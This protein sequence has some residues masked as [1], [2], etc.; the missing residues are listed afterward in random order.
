M[1][2]FSK[3]LISASLFIIFSA[4]L[5]AEGMVISETGSSGSFPL[6][7]GN[8][9]AALIVDT[10]DAEVVKIAAQAFSGDIKLLTGATPTIQSTINN[11]PPVIIGTLSKSAL[12]DQLA[13]SGKINKSRLEG[14]WE[15]FCIV[16][17][18]NPV[19]NASKALVVA[20]SDPRG[21][22]FGVFELSRMMGV[23]PWIWWADVIPETRSAIYVSGD[24]VFGPPSVKYRGIFI[25][26]EDWGMQP[27]AAN[28]M[29]TE[30]NGGK[31]DI[32]PKTYEHIFELMLRTKSNYLWPA[33]HAC[34]KAFWYYKENVEVARRYSIVMGSS[35]CEPML[36]NNEDE[37][38]SNFS[39]EYPGVTRGD[40]NWKTNS[41]VIKNYWIDRV[42][43]SV[44]N[45]AVY[46]LGM[47]GVHDTQML[48][49]NNDDERAAALKQI[50]AAQRDILETYLQKSKE[51]I[52][53][54]FC[55][56][57][58]ALQ[59]YNKGIDLPGDVTL[60]W[61]DD[62]HGY[63]R[64]LSTPA[65]QLRNG[66]GG[67]YYHYSYRGIPRDYLWLSG[68]SPALVSFEM[69]K[70]Y[71]LNAKRIWIFNVGDLKQAEF[72]YQ[73]SMDLAWNINAWQP[74][75][76]LDY[77]TF[78][79]KEIFG[80]N[81]AGPIS[82]IKKEY[83]RLAT[84][85]KPELVGLV[86]YTTKEME[87]RIADYKALVTQSKIIEAQLPE[88]LQAAY[89]QLI[90]YPVEGA[91]SMNEK[92]L[93]AALSFKYAAQRNNEKALDIAEKAQAAYRN[94]PVLTRKYNKEISD[95]KWD[96]MMDW[97]PDGFRFFYE[98]NTITE[99][100]L[101]DYNAIPAE[102]PDHVTSI[103]ASQYKTKN[104]AGKTIETIEGLGVSF[105]SV[106]VWPLDMASYTSH[107]I[108]TAP[109]VEYEIPLKKGSNKII[110]KCLPTFPLYTGLNLRYA[111][112]LDGKIPEFVDIAC[113]A[114]SS[115]WRTNVVRGFSSGEHVYHSDADKNILVKI[116]FSDPGL[117]LSAIEVSNS[118]VS[119][120]TG[121][122]VNSDFE[123]DEEGNPLTGLRRG[124]PYGWERKGDLKS[125]SWGTNQDASNYHG[126]NACWYSSSP[127]PSNFELSQTIKNLPAGE[128][129][130][131][132]LLAVP[133]NRMTTQ[134]LF[135]NNHVQYYGKESD[136]VSN[137]ASGEINT[138][139]GHTPDAGSENGSLIK[140]KDMALKFI[141]SEGDNLTIG[142]RSDNKKSD[143]T[144]VNNNSSGWFK[145]DHF[146]LECLREM[147]ISTIKQELEDLIREAQ[148][149]YE[150][151]EVGTMLDQYLKADRDN[152]QVAINAAQVVYQK[153]GATLIECN[154][155]VSSLKAAV[156][157]YERSKITYT[158]YIVNP[159][160]EY[161]SE[162][163]P[164]DGTTLRG[165]PYGWKQT[166][167]IKGNSY[168]INN[169]AKNISGNNACWY[170]SLPMPD[171]FELYQT[172]SGLPA[173]KYTVRCRM[174]AP[175]K[176]L[177]TQ[178]LFANNNVQYLGYETD[179]DKN[180]TEGEINSYANLATTY[181]YL[182]QEM[183][184]DVI[185]GKGENLKLG[186]RTS[187]MKPDGSRET[188]DNHGWFKVDHF[189]LELKELHEETGLNLVEEGFFRI[190]GE[191]GG[192]RIFL[193]KPF[194]KAHIRVISLS[195][196]LIH[197]RSLYGAESKITLPKGLYVIQVSLDG[198]N[199]A[200]KILV[201]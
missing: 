41:T 134:R 161:K 27:W 196:Y 178:R 146:R 11:T 26:D 29:D 100:Q 104:N 38:R 159:S 45:D 165:V 194:E 8:V 4:A 57:K 119:P 2:N 35:H 92:V 20:G 40:W 31:G 183:E 32:G 15:T 64:Q 171:N 125:N 170:S 126:G 33:M 163:I 5:F 145:V 22:A 108:T 133:E 58:E 28:K 157:E 90:G 99:G 60:L 130:V 6:V 14:K 53:Q 155:A 91:A 34:T 43:E 67:V 39:L 65:E 137:L 70:A 150:S 164:N 118:N 42:K 121:K 36:R 72:E 144:V 140:L 167:S 50:I 54:L 186:V 184:A 124:D 55:P 82:T 139:A 19:P 61:P 18:D 68:T 182:L 74:A 151:T 66:G 156:K 198:Q 128:Y 112:S 73:F 197:D 3:F 10:N 44:N 117:V 86:N 87:Q 188:S 81:F 88:R 168:G 136:Y 79:A 175:I 105:S 85:G 195:G 173:G 179:Y 116:Y 127:M 166:G 94:I 181:E 52:P 95:G 176:K 23:S 169:D 201:E 111:I 114:E 109:S 110:V 199:K 47:R 7:S 193:E 153:V 172:L 131:R 158:S 149:L 174:A 24:E 62:N 101:D 122:I 78:W 69:H 98:P 177:T 93:G 59:H 49:Y 142:I 192:C 189:R 154:N 89:F 17:V 48:G 56:Y 77:T 132:C 147:S 97:A 107:D 187:N 138:F 200:G 160:F 123:Y 103:S 25:N 12:I 148:N 9:P 13:A 30:I 83:L 76:S 51:T 113:V 191:E 84:A 46:T 96:G 120:L 162:G 80:E 63:M 129:I 1:K 143:G 115:K 21:T 141:L 106:T 102:T 16:V 135:A 185:L 152:F 37:W 180:L 75:E 71:A 190:T